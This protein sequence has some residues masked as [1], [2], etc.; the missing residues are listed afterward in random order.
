MGV[1][2][3]NNIFYKPAIGASGATEKGLFDDGLDVADGLIEGN[4][5]AN[6]KLSAFAAT[7]SAEL[8]GVI[9]DETGS[10]KAV[11]SDSPTLVAPKL[12]EASAEKIDLTEG[13]IKF[14]VVVNPSADPNTLYDYEV[15][16]WTPVIRGSGTA[17]VYEIGSYYCVYEKIGSNVHLE[18]KITMA[19]SITGGGT[20]SFVITGIPFS[21]EASSDPIGS[22]AAHMMPFG[23]VMAGIW[24]I[25][26][27]RLGILMTRNDTSWQ[28]FA[29]S[30]VMAGD[31]MIF[32]IDYRI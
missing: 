9:S 32:S 5:P 23:S 10:G 31:V 13:Q 16:E 1:P 20:S 3:L 19:S 17:G 4:K 12:G 22:L 26:T 2:T 7:T 14:P 21:K 11:F 30:S 29:I 27:A 24:F 8:A 28:I 18:G 25:G 15:G 6:N